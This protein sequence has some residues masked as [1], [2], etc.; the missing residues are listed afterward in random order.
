[1]G[2]KIIVSKR[3]LERLQ[4]FLNAFLEFLNKHPGFQVFVNLIP[5]VSSHSFFLSLDCT[6]TCTNIQSET[7]SEN[8]LGPQQP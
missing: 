8:H 7:K 3:I 6:V 1:M 2:F 5:F 4:S